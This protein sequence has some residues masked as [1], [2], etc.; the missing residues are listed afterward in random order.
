MPFYFVIFSF[1]MLVGGCAE[2]PY[3]RQAV[4]GQLDLLARRRPLAD[5]LEDGQTPPGLRARLELAERLRR[6]AVEEL[7]LTHGDSFRD[8]AD[9]G[10]PYAAWVVFATPEFS[11]T[12]RIWCFPFVGCL[13][14]RGYFR[15]QD[16]ETF[17][18]GLRREGLDVHDADAPAY[19]TL[20]WFADPLLNTCIE[21]PRTRLA[22][23]MFHELAHERL[24]LAGDT[25]FN[26]AF[27]DAVSRV[28]VERWLRR[29][30]DQAG[31]AI[32]KQEIAK[33]ERFVAQVRRTR[34]R[35]VELYARALP[36][37]E[38]R[39]H[40]Q[41][42]L[43]EEARAGWDHPWW[44]KGVNNAKLLSVNLYSGRVPA[45]TPAW[46]PSGRR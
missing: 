24:Y 21:W 45:I 16:A 20:G 41:A 17:A 30:G 44:R 3:Y 15:R 38:M 31:L 7:G 10:R 8:Y 46:R 28:G 19:S 43:A 42:I 5:M 4:E 32:H 27:A 6:F 33:R 9:L 36:E 12:P 13:A 34:A 14:Y 29:Q 40:K 18:A 1:L 11:L 22:G 39:E 25:A 37:P 35:L 2:L 23:L 26:E